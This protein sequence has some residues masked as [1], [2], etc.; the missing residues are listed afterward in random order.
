MSENHSNKTVSY[1]RNGN[2]MYPP[3]SSQSFSSVE[4][5]D[6]DWDLAQFLGILQRRALVIAGVATVVM[7]VVTYATLKQK[8]IYE[9]NFQLLVEPVNDDDSL[10]KLSLA[11]DSSLSKQSLD[12]ESQ[13]LVLKSPELMG[14]ILKTLQAY[15]PEINYESLLEFLTIRRLGETKII[16]VKYQNND[17]N[18]IKVVLDII[19]KSYLDYSLEKR[20][21]KLSQ[22]VQFVDKQL[23]AIK[24]RVNQLQKQ[25]Q[26]FR[27]Q[28]DFITPET[29]AQLIAEQ[30]K[31]LANQR[32]VVDQQLAAV[33]ANFSSLEAKKGKLA[34]LNN[35]PVYQQLITQLRQLE[36]Q[37]AGELARFQADNPAIQTLQEKKQNLLPL[38]QQEAQRVL[39]LK[40]AEVATQIQSL[41][42][43]SQE[44]ENAENQLAQKSKQLPVLARQYSELQR[45]LQIATE[46]LNRFLS[47]R[48]NLQIQI[49]Q[50]ELPW[51]LIQAAFTP[52]EPISPNIPRNLILGFV[53]SF[54]LGIGVS[55]LMEKLDNTYHS[56]N[57]LKE[58]IKLP[59]LGVLPFDKKVQN[60]QSL[61]LLQKVSTRMF[62]SIPKLS[63]IF[64]RQSPRDRYYGQ[65]QFWESLQVL[66]T[67]IQ[68]LNSD[69]PIRSLVISS[70]LPGDGKSTVAFQLAQIAATMGKRVL[71]VDADLRR[72]NIHNRANLNNLWGLS[73]L[74]STNIPVE[75]VIRQLPQ[76]NNL[77]IITS[78]PT[79]PDPA[80][81]L[82]SA[83]MKQLMADFQKNFDLVI[84]DLPPIVGLVD[85]RLL[86][87]VTDGVVLV[88]RLEKT[89]KSA[90]IQ[91]QDSL[92]ISPI[93]ILGVVVNGDKTKFSGYNDYYSSGKKSTSNTA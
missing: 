88:V 87:P 34:I 54:L 5:G 12:Y 42:V 24:N 19:A 50:T 61:S 64:R 18:K 31:L 29:Q 80:R 90:F 20:Q 35:A 2:G 25:L 45:D 1:E 82:S 13:I 73:S 83:K 70:A 27:Q 46:S 10:K 48:E 38:L 7:G 81:L 65:G 71:L 69:Q 60:S 77:S 79:P 84:Y 33:R 47:T 52:E 15:D 43:Q 91:A 32:L 86:A 89:D 49:A 68:L 93:N 72:P 58:K 6:N 75:Q 8:P 53:A 14:S 17:P 41:E 37:T 44:L 55:L 26:I 78:G 92:K 23:P 21:T 76:M 16:E 40:V 11:V 28:Y 51:E 36:A 39:G 57:N 56:T 4:T 67:N 66:Y 63:N 59:L 9:S 3:L 74:I 22:G 30:I 62:P 85:V